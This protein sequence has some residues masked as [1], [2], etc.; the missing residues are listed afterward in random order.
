ML[1]YHA[2][3]LTRSGL[4][5]WSRLIE[6]IY[7]GNVLFFSEAKI[8]RKWQID[9]C[10]HIGH[11]NHN[12]RQTELFRRYKIRAVIWK[13]SIAYSIDSN[14]S[15]HF[16]WLFM[17]FETPTSMS[18]ASTCSAVTQAEESEFEAK[19]GRA[20]IWSWECIE[21]SNRQISC[22]FVRICLDPC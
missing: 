20:F 6:L 15:N 12:A 16:Y 4:R 14:F 19:A 1:I 8:L 9:S 18:S 13:A 21:I 3:L 7:Q 17:A 5:S 10:K 11:W 2:T 22:Y